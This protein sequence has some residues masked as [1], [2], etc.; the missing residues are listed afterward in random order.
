M[1]G[2]VQYFKILGNIMYCYN[3]Q[4]GK[5]HAVNLDTGERKSYE[6]DGQ[7]VSSLILGK[8]K[9]MLLDVYS[10][11]NPDGGD[12][13]RLIVRLNPDEGT[14][15]AEDSKPGEW[16]THYRNG[17]IYTEDELCIYKYYPGT[18]KKETIID[19]LEEMPFLNEEEYRSN[20]WNEISY[21]DDYITMEVYYYSDK[22]KGDHSKLLVYDYDG[23]LVDREKL[24]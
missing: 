21:C 17:A 16:I 9:E 7:E 3:R 22:E 13:S 11:V 15:I 10:T 6:C 8:D 12:S 4:D 23:K 1:D 19:I 20:V 24:W 2:E 5:L 18:W 14:E